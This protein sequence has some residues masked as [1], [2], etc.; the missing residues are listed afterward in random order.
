MFFYQKIVLRSWH[1]F[2]IDFGANLPPFSFQKSSKIVSDTDLERHRFFDRFLHRF[3]P[4]FVSILGP[5]LGPCWP[6]FRSKW[7][8][9]INPSHFF[10]GSMLFFG[11]LGRPGPLQAPFWLD[12]GGVGAPFWRFLASI[13]PYFCKIW[14]GLC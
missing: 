5:K 13:F 9:G 8:E 14:G 1:R 7:G 6:H 10:V 3:F 4:H 12:F 2:L 11:F